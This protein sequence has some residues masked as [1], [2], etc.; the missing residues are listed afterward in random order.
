M[1]EIITLAV[2]LFVVTIAPREYN[3]IDGHAVARQNV[4]VAPPSSLQPLATA[5][6]VALQQKK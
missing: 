1:F 5:N 6:A 2:A 3:V 4:P